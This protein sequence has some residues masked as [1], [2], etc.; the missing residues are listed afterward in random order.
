MPNCLFVGICYNILMI[1]IIAG[2]KKN[3]GWVREACAEYEKRLHK[4]FLAEW[5]F[6]EE[7]KLNDKVSHLAPSDF[8]ILLDEH[9]KILSSPELSKT[10]AGP[11]EAGRNVVFLIGG[12]FGHFSEAILKRANLVWSLSKLVLPHQHCRVIVAEQLYRAQE[13]YLGHPY[14]HE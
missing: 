7:S 5:Q 4:P 8:L 13:I 10:V 2:G 14:H 9:G 1:T 12:A 3:N 6:V 11:L